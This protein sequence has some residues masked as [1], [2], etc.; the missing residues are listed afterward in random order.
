M[1][2]HALLGRGSPYSLAA[3]LRAISS[4]LV[5]LMGGV[6]LL[7]LYAGIIE[8]FLS[9]LHEPRVPYTLKILF[10]TIQ[11]TA[12]ILYLLRAGRKDAGSINNTV[13]SVPKEVRF[14][15]SAIPLRTRRRGSVQP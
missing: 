10:G 6:V 12:L 1:L 13:K 5:T 15:A 9:Q 7:L 11:L 14:H 2:G 4:D 8:A 3:R